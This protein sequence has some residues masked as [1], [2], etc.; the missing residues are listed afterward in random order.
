MRPT[1]R[2]SR[3]L[4]IF[5]LNSDVFLKIVYHHHLPH[6]ALQLLQ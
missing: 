6:F 4:K 5:N 1:Y 2:Y 3:F